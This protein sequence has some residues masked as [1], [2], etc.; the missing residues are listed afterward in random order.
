MVGMV[1]RIA[2]VI[3]STIIYLAVFGLLG[4][5]VSFIFDVLGVISRAVSDPLFYVLWAVLGIFC[6]LFSYDSGG[7]I[8]APESKTDWRSR[9]DAGTIGL[10]VV[11]LETLTLIALSIPSALLISDSFSQSITFFVAVFIGMLF[12]HIAFRP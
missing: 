9:K 12:A 4:G 5:I 7:G 1:K 6:G 10:Q 11:V 2:K 3:G 8:L